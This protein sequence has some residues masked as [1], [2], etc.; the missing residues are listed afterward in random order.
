MKKK[1]VLGLGSNIGN[2]YAYILQ[3]IQRLKKLSNGKLHTARVYENPPWGDHQQ[4][5]FLNT[6]VC[7]ETDLCLMDIFQLIKEIEALGKRKKT[8]RWGPR[9]IDIDILFYGDEVV[10]NDHLTVPHKYLHER[11]FVLAPIADILPDYIH[12][13]TGISIQEHLNQI[14]NA[15]LTIFTE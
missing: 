8:R 14:D 7:L 9:S 3:C 12:P 13:V 4:P 2:R 15:E 5:S 1:L 10:Q 6:A 11:A